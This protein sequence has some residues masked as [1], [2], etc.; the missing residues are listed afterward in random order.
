MQLPKSD[1]GA[2]D[3]DVIGRE[4]YDDN[5]GGSSHF[6]SPA[7]DRIILCGDDVLLMVLRTGLTY[8]YLTPCTFANHPE[9]RSRG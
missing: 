2:A 4:D 7:C 3:R 6:R 5:K 9:D 8:D 1:P